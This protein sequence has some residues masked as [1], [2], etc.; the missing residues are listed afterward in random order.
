MW[1]CTYTAC[2]R[3]HQQV[4]LTTRGR[5]LWT[6]A[7]CETQSRLHSCP[8]SHRGPNGSL[9]QSRTASRNATSTGQTSP[10]SD[11]GGNAAW[12]APA[13]RAQQTTSQ[14]GKTTSAILRRAARQTPEAERM[15]KP[16]LAGP[17][18]S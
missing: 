5:I 8:R 10:G 13:P 11:A 16:R 1:E 14:Q 2:S 7:P 17:C 15:A 18:T 6:N 9:A 4:G 12:L 3:S